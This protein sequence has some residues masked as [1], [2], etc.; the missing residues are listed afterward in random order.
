MFIVSVS[1]GLES[2]H[3]LA[4]SPCSRSHPGAIKVSARLGSHLEAVLGKP[5][6]PAPGVVGIILFFEA[7]GF[8]TASFFKAR[9]GK[10]GL[11]RWTLCSYLTTYI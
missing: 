4:E 3:G 2:G 1:V 10:D 8:V 6:F 11:V 7:V 9:K 5:H